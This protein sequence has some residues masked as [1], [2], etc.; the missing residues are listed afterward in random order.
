MTTTTREGPF[1]QGITDAAVSSVLNATGGFAGGAWEIAK[2]TWFGTIIN[3]V[4]SDTASNILSTPSIITLDNQ[5]AKLLVGQEVPITTG[6][7][8]LEG[9]RLDTR[10]THGTGCTLSSAIATFLGQGVP[11]EQAIDRARGFVRS[12]LRAAPGFGAG[13]GPL[14]HHAARG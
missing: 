10:H 14:G 4:K 12:A 8:L 5:E 6:E 9:P 11:L 3:A 1:G 2:N 7:T 13:A